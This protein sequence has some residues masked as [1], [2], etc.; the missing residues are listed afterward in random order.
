MKRFTLLSLLLLLCF[1]CVSK[2][3]QS[4]KADFISKIE[5]PNTIYTVNLPIEPYDL[6]YHIE[7]TENNEFSLIVSMDLF[8]GSHFISPHA[9]RDFKGKFNISI[10]DNENLVLEDTFLETPRSVEIFDPHPFTNGLVNWVHVN[11]S[12]KH[13][14]KIQSQDDFDV[15]GL[16]I[17][18]IEPRCSLEKI[19]F[20]IKYRSGKMIIEKFMC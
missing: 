13:Q 14:L 1:S 5:E 10:E 17:F 16:I 7:E 8:N 9:K 4:N 2:S 12:Y 15:I 3:P 6:K 18:T 20:I 11:T 19:S